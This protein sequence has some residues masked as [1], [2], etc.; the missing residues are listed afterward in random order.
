M[1]IGYWD[2]PFKEALEM[3]QLRILICRVDNNDENKMTEIASFAVAER[4]VSSLQAETALD[5]IENDTHQ[6]GQ[7]FL[8]RLLQ[9]QWEEID[10]QL[11]EVHR[12]RFS[13]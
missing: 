4:D 8:R 3:S 5:E 10:K 11:V 12:Q 1:R 7:Q 2:K 6:V 13:P 9:A